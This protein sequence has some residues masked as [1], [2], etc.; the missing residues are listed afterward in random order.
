MRICDVLL[1]FFD[2]VYINIDEKD[3]F[4]AEFNRRFVEVLNLHPSSLR[5][6]CLV[7]TSFN[8]EN[9]GISIFSGAD[10][11][12]FIRGV[13]LSENFDK[14]KK[15]RR[16]MEGK[17]LNVGCEGSFPSHTVQRLMLSKGAKRWI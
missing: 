16:E 6:M 2:S 7:V 4:A 5:W 10:P 3:E 17:F 15:R 1:N 8:T 13:Q 11:G 9:K 14:Q 12:I